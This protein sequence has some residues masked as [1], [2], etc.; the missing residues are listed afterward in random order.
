MQPQPP[1]S[2]SKKLKR[3][4]ELRDFIEHRKRKDKVWE[5]ALYEYVD[6]ILELAP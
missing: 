1:L 2:F 5:Q 4:R 3:A 6:L